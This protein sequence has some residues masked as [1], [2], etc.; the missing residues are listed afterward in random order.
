[1][2]AKRYPQ[3]IWPAR[4]LSLCW[5]FVHIF[6]FPHSMYLQQFLPSF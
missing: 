3:I 2:I 5:L 1:L 6:V 4:A